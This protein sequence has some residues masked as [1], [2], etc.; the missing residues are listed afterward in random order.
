M[1]QAIPWTLTI[2][3]DL[4]LLAL[5]RAFV[6]GVCRVGGFDENTTH[7]VVLATDEAMNNVIRHAH[8]GKTDLPIQILCFLHPDRIEIQLH[9]EGEPFDIAQVPF[10]D[11]AELRIGGRGV[12]LMRRLMDELTTCARPD[13]GNVLRMV[14]RCASHRPCQ[15]N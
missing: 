15:P 3:S 7:A 10:L 11:P 14:K 4:H 1:A 2:H 9:D 6:E 12:F 13:R 5:A 8:Q